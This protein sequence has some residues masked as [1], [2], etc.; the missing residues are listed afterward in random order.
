M[1]TRLSLIKGKNLHRRNI[2]KGE[3]KKN[4]QRLKKLCNLPRGWGWGGRLK[5][6]VH[7]FSYF[8]FS[9]SFLKGNSIS[10]SSLCQRGVCWGLLRV[11][12]FI[13]ALYTHTHIPFIFS[14]IF[15]HIL[16]GRFFLLLLLAGGWLW[17]NNNILGGKKSKDPFRIK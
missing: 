6:L 17:A 16:D 3:N 4:S 7:S 1:Y 11:G 14:P 13:L 9:L 15:S 12:K 8:F 5:V 10:F 2:Q